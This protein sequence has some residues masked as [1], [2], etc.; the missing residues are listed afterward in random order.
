MSLELSSE[1]LNMSESATFAISDKA[2]KLKALG[3]DVINL[4]VGEPDFQTPDP[5][6]NS[7]KEAKPYT[8]Y[9]SCWDHFNKRCHHTQT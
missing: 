4:G 6:K 3:H 2:K 5:I 1:L 7:A 9:C 8:L